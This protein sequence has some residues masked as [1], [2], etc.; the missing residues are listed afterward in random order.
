MR[1]YLL[2]VAGLALLAASSGAFAAGNTAS[3]AFTVS[4][5]VNTF[6]AVTATAMNFGTFT[7]AIPANTAAT[8]TAS[9]TCANGAAYALSLA[10]AA[11]TASATATMSNGAAT[12]PASLTVSTAGQTGN[13]AVQNTP[14][15]G[16][17]VA[18]VASPNVGAY[19]VSQ[20]IY[21][22]Y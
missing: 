7:G 4:V 14:I 18:G 21:V 20:S 9:V 16:L 2:P 15:N 5:T 8:S 1:K 10:P 22:L 11:G 19:S 12:I 13:G 3:Q 17:I 6:C